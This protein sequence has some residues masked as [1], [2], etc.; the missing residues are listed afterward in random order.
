MKKYKKIIAAAILCSCM[1]L[2][3]CSEEEGIPTVE[4]ENASSAVS[5]TETS[6]KTESQSDDKKETSKKPQAPAIDSWK[7]L[8]IQKLN[9]YFREIVEYNVPDGAFFELIDINKDKTPE[10]VISAPSFRD[11]KCEVYTVN[12]GKLVDLK[13]DAD[14]GKLFYNPELK[15]MATKTTSEGKTTTWVGEV[16]NGA[17]KQ[18]LKAVE[19]INNYKFTL[20]GK[21]LSEYEYYEAVSDYEDIISSPWVQIGKKN[22]FEAESITEKVNSWN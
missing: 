20:N 12:K 5:K 8:Y 21:E 17:L 4:S 2:G 10:L 11:A 7:V 6:V 15:Q 13:V 3:G 18:A 1:L 19:D 22:P 14:F 16:E 9:D